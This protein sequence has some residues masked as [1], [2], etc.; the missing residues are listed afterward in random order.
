MKIKILLLVEVLEDPVFINILY[1]IVQ[2]LSIIQY[3]ILFA[4]LGLDKKQ[5]NRVALA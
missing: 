2:L 3:P 1:S 4:N 5:E